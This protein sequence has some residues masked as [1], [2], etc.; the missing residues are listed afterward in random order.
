MKKTQGFTLIE[1]M[2]VVAIIG[3][4]AAI[5]IPA[6]NGYIKQAKVNAV[7]T[8]AEAAVRLIKNEV[9]KLASGG[10]VVDDIIDHLNVGG[11]KSPFLTT[12]D[13]YSETVTTEGTVRIQ[14]LSAVNSGTGG[15]SIPAAGTT[16]QITVGLGT[17]L[18]VADYDW[19]A[20][21]PDGYSG[22]GIQVTIE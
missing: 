19:L 21:G 13:A 10:G 18:K 22:T 14:G 15:Q 11:K 6:Y 7:R 2:I 16:V 5:A 17:V 9:A 3:I 1:L 8:N 20:A 12:A 4:L